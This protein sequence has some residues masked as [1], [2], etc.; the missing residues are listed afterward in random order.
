MST[1]NSNSSVDV[2]TMDDVRKAIKEAIAEHAAS[3]NHP[4]ATQVEPGLVTLSNE[5]DSDS[6]LTAVTSK[7]V[8]IINDNANS[9]LSKDQNGADITDKTAFVKNIGLMEALTRIKNT[10]LL[11]ENGWWKCGDT[12]LIIQWGI[13][14]QQG[15]G[16]GTY[17]FPLPIK[18]PNKGLWALGYSS[19]ALNHNADTYSGSA[20]LLDNV[21]LKVT[22][23]N[24]LPTACIVIG[25]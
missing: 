3:R 15:E 22:V 10:A 24:K 5:T 9:R 18:F 13:F 17:I 8:K 23:D 1:K 20:E 7:A 16:Y 19:Q 25:Y 11:S 4:Y 6:E 14:G 21:N 12:G 2:P